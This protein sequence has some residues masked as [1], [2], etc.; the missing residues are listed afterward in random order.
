MPTVAQLKQAIRRHKENSGNCPV[1]S[2]L[3]KAQLLDIVDDLGIHMPAP[4]PRAR[5]ARRA[6]RARPARPARPPPPPFIPPILR[7][8]M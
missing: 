5:P 8:M 6:R 1:Y 7:M 4:P 2:K 3:R